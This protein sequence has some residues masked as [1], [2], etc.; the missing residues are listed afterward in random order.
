MALRS[1]FSG[2]RDNRDR[3]GLTKLLLGID[4]KAARATW[5]AAV[6]LLLLAAI[7]TIR[8]T[9][10]VFALALLL[11]YLLQPLASKIS[12][13]FPRKNRTPALAL[14]Y[15]LVIGLLAG[16]GIVVGS[17]VALEA[18]YFI[19]HPP[20]VLGTVNQLRADHPDL[21]PLIDSV[22]GSL[23][24]QLGEVA[25]FGQRLS[26]RILAASANLI[27][28]VV[29][30]ILS[31]F[32][33]KDGASIQDGFLAMFSA[34]ESRAKAAR[35]LAEVHILM[36]QYMRAL[37]VLCCTAMAVFGF[38][39]TMLGVR[40]A[41]L[42]A[43]IAFFCEF[44]PMA[45]PIAEIVVILVVCLLTG[46]PHIWWLAAFL[47]VFRIVQ[48]YVIWPRLMSQGIQLHPLL[49]IFGI[50]SGGAIGGV[51]GVFL[52][53]PVLVLVRLALFPIPAG[54]SAKLP[55]APHVAANV[56]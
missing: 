17:R 35:T 52:S 28:I 36:L 1:R 48:D 41:L 34:G 5:T 46:Y 27:Y 39:L 51:A 38:V 49:L 26:L 24:Q 20:D 33:L 45:G 30:P 22:H 44:V 42:L 53:V 10:V 9:L 19:A 54:P 37:L 21:S 50:F 23:Q 15:L 6:T 40:Y 14:T 31:F 8:S 12:R 2:Q 55:P 43:T 4:P 3:E 25:S 47:G 16:I 18:R 13:H 56:S 11:A 32:M 7:Y 29:I